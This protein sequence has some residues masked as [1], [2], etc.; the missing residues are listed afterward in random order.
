MSDIVFARHLQNP[1]ELGKHPIMETTFLVDVKTEEWISTKTIAIIECDIEFWAKMGHRVRLPISEIGNP[2]ENYLDWI[3]SFFNHE[4][5][6]QA[7]CIIAGGEATKKFDNIDRE[8]DG[9]I[10]LGE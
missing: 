6:H 1:C 9:I 5:L 10:V 2:H 4:L 8:G 3:M 7:I